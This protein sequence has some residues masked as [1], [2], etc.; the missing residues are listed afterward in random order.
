MA[1]YSLF[2]NG[3]IRP[4]TK[5]TAQFLPFNV[6]NEFMLDEFRQEVINYVFVHAESLEG[7]S[8]SRLNSLVKNLV[9][10]PGFRNSAQAP[11]GLKVRNSV[12]AFEKSADF[13]GHILQCWA[14]LHPQMAI[15]VA[16][17]LKEKG[18]EILPVDANRT[19]LP[20]II[21]EWPEGETYEKLDAMYKQKVPDY[22]GDSNDV[23]LM[24]VWLSGRLPLND[25]SG[26]EE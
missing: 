23:R 18:W 16:E 22:S 5:K 20:G 21:P 17:I 19:V 2:M 11:A 12:K 10:V 9:Q 24:A 8:R 14:E 25:T 1:E 4:M 3:I 7:P 26:E 13:T 6:I 15:T